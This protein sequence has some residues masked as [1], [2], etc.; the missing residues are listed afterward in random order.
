[1]QIEQDEKEEIPEELKTTTGNKYGIYSLN[2]EGF[3]MY[4][5]NK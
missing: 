2:G 5:R 1:M 3:R 4:L